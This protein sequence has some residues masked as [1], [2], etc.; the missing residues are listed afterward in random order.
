M[1]QTKQRT[2]NNYTPGSNPAFDKS[3]FSLSKQTP[4]EATSNIPYCCNLI[5]PEFSEFADI[6]WFAA[7]NLGNITHF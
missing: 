1:P 3:H 7:L 2:T 6:N 4:R 5:R